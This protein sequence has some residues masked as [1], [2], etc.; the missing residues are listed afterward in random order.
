LWRFY[1]IFISTPNL[2]SSH[3]S[4][5]IGHVLSIEMGMSDE[6][7]Y[8][9]VGD[10]GPFKVITTAFHQRERERERE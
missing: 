7:V 5:C 6:L 3:A 10:C 1:Q 4:V 8:I 9:L 2:Q